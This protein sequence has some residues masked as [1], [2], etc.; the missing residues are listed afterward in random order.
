MF[1]IKESLSILSFLVVFS[2]SLN[3][4]QK[5]QAATVAFYNVENL[6]DT[7]V[8]VDYIDGTRSQNDP[9]YHVTI[10]EADIYKYDTVYFRG[11]YTHEAI[12]GKKVIRPQILQ[13]DEFSP[14]GTKVWNHE[15]YQR[16]L[17][18][19]SKVIVELGKEETKNAPVIVG[20]SEVETLQTVEDL[21]NHPI[22]KP[23]NY[24]AIHF[25]SF[26]AR[27]IDLGLIYQKN[28]FQVTFAKPYP[29]EIYSP[30]GKRIYTRDILR[31]TG[32]LDGEEMTFLVNHWPSRSGGE[33]RSMPN[34]MKAAEA[35]KKIFDEIRA[36][37]PEAKII[38]MGDFNDDPIN[39]SIKIGMGAIGKKEKVQ[40]EDIY[41][42]M[43]AIYK[44]KGVGT[45]AYRDAWN[46]F[47]Q[48]MMTGTLVDNAK[49]YDSYKIFKVEI[50][51]PSYLRSPSGPY[52][53]FP[54]RMFGGDTF[55][56]EGYSDHFPIYTVLLRNV[57]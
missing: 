10:P 34:R 16:K 25:N 29:I 11:P 38:A 3:A 8:S 40:K 42:P 48:F 56:P 12:Q 47:D 31:V 51:S 45:L 7:I 20:L 41:N 5:Y 26:D 9:L 52:K 30:E 6:F 2:T 18:Q 54:Y 13:K 1:K 21:A 19:L 43:E 55:Y 53:G 39:P 23:Y 15:R 50:Y 28:R 46:L 33:K 22:L 4:Q 57:K 17:H 24:G 32:L 27:G 44:K 35:M 36:E 49:Q 37:N 14:K